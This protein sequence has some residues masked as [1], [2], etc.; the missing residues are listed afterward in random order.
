MQGAAGGGASN[1]SKPGVCITIRWDT[2]RRSVSSVIK[3][4]QG[5]SV[6]ADNASDSAVGLQPGAMYESK[7]KVLQVSTTAQRATSGTRAQAHAQDSTALDF[8]LDLDLYLELDLDRRNEERR[9]RREEEEGEGRKEK[10]RG[11][12]NID[13]Y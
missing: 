1:N 9:G 8:D 12:K 3:N 2:S 13:C 6:R 11:V 7:R 10:G 5:G 4:V